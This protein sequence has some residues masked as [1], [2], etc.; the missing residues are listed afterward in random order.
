MSSQRPD[1]YGESHGLK[2]TDRWP[3]GRAFVLAAGVGGLVVSG[4]LAT[5]FD[6]TSRRDYVVDITRAEV[7]QLHEVIISQ[8]NQIRVLS[9]RLAAHEVQLASLEALLDR[10]RDED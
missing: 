10:D 8:Q 4:L 7:S 6:A 2:R 5:L 1:L 3:D 9:E